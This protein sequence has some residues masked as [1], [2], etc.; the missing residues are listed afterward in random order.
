LY[1]FL[2]TVLEGETRE[3]YRLLRE[4]EYAPSPDLLAYGCLFLALD[5]FAHGRG[6]GLPTGDLSR[7]A[8][9]ILTGGA[10]QALSEDVVGRVVN[11]L[12]PGSGSSPVVLVDRQY[13]VW[14]DGITWSGHVSL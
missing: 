12:L 11:L 9:V 14:V 3:I 4:G 13:Q 8:Q 10:A 6:P 2:E 5:R 1:E 7:L